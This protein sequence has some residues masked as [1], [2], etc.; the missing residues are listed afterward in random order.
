MAVEHFEEAWP[1]G[2]AV[3]YHWYQKVGAVLYVFFCFEIGIFLFLFPWLEVWNR[4]YFSGLSPSWS[5]L[6][7]SPYFRGAVSGVGLIDIGISFAELLRLRRF[8]RRGREQQSA[9]GA[10]VR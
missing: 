1:A 7:N 9:T 6:W 4:N 10:P 3:R 8:A 2:E 5:E